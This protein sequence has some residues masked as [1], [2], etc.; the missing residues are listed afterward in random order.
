MEKVAA[1]VV[2]VTVT[3]LAFEALLL[4]IRSSRCA[5]MQEP[6]CLSFFL[7][8]VAV[9]LAFP[10]LLGAGSILAVFILWA[11]GAFLI[12]ARGRTGH[13]RLRLPWAFA[14]AGFACSLVLGNLCG[15]GRT[16]LYSAFDAAGT[17][18]LG[19]FAAKL[20]LGIGRGSR[21]TPL[22]AA[23]VSA[24][25]WF[26][27]ASVD[28]VLSSFGLRYPD[29]SVIPLFTL[30]LCLGWLVFQEGYP[31]RAGWRGRLAALELEERLPHAAYARVLDQETALA[32]Q[33][34]LVAAGLLVLGV[35]HEFKNTLSYIRAV[36]ERGLDR[37]EADSKDESLR[38][39]MEHVETGKESAVTL[40]ER[41]SREGRE[42]PCLIDPER[43]LVRFLRLI[44][45][46]YRG[47][48]I[49]MPASLE[50]GVRFIARKSEVEQILHNLVRNAV[51]GLQCRGLAE[52]KLIEVSS[53]R[54]DGRAILDVKDNAGG[55]T[56][57]AARRLFTP[58][59][60]QTGGTGLGLYLSRSLASQNGGTLEYLPADGGSVFRLSFPIAS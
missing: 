35:A 46:G 16:V 3:L 57:A 1:I 38:L 20:M 24:C 56:A 54:V 40:L 21:S 12:E 43:D 7:A 13:G 31:S 42:E 44:R 52:Q 47:E 18:A 41:L 23:L 27:V 58:R 25:T 32:R 14:C 19:A 17:C 60:S 37:P 39:L 28:T 59:Y 26:V 5:R 48:G 11:A 8:A 33:D 2:S 34:R 29:L 55:M 22:F 15:L 45:A 4:A 49:L 30:S 36:A 6:L 53:R 9:G 10:F 50:P 51:E